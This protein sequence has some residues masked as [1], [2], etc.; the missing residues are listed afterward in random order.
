MFRSRS[1]SGSPRAFTLIELLVVIAIIA[2]LIGMLL[3]AVQKV[4]EAAA[5]S[6][7]ANNLKQLTLAVNNYVSTFDGILPPGRTAI[8][9]GDRWWFGQTTTSATTIDP[10]TGHLMPYVEN[11]AAV[12]RCPSAE[13]YP[14][15]KKYLGG[16]GGYGYA[17]RYLAP[18]SFPPPNFTPVWRPVRINAVAATSQTVAFADAAGT[19][20]DPW[21]T[22]TPVLI[23][24]PLLEPPTGQ[25]PAV[26]FRHTGSANVA[27]LDGHV[28]AHS[29]G[30][31]N[32]PPS[33]EPASAT[34]LRDRYRLFDLG[35]NDELWDLQ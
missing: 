14:I 18:L 21:P 9:G 33:W 27:Y 34:Q 8:V 28:E 30:T 11:N 6:S 2:I 16:T 5:R 24:V 15:Q 23:E 35:V 25:Y 20:I 26:H 31:R 29:T 17:Y 19:W 10:R 1:R 22:G 32:P 4:R 12:L 7:C 3:P 13:G